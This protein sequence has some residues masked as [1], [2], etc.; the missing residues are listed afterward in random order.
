MNKI[1]MIHVK[2]LYRDS[3]TKY[4]GK[5]RRNEW[6]EWERMKEQ[7]EIFIYNVWMIVRKITKFRPTKGNIYNGVDELLVIVDE[8]D[9][10]NN[11]QGPSSSS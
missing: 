7:W 8:G 4:L 5:K 11:G 1:S 6:F 10:N 2:R 3:C 9:N